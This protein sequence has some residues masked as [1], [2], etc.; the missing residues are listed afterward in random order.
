MVSTSGY[1]VHGF[2]GTGTWLREYGVYGFEGT[3]VEGT[4]T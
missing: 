3:G 1:R 2:V 4:G